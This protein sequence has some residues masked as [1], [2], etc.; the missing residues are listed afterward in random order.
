MSFFFALCLTRN[1]KEVIFI[2][3]HH[4][5]GR[6]GDNIMTE[7]RI[8]ALQNLKTARGQIDG[9][10]KMLGD[11]RYCIDISN[12][13]LASQALLKKANLH[14]LT[15]HLNSCVRTAMESGIG[16]EE[17]IQEIELLMTKIMK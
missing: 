1:K 9:I 10:I 8:K 11:E 3:P 7:E 2:I 15:G 16:N 4:P 13:I 12:Q 14:I 5:W 6:D 17:K